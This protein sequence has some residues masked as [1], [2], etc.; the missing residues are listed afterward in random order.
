MHFIPM[1]PEISECKQVGHKWYKCNG[2]IMF[3]EP[4]LIKKRPGK[5]CYTDFILKMHFLM[6]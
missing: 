2:C 1:K 3:I 5:I 4:T 6:Y